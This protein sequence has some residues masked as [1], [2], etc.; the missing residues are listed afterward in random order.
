MPARRRQ[1]TRRWRR[2]EWDEVREGIQVRQPQQDPEPFVVIE[3]DQPEIQVVQCVAQPVQVLYAEVQQEVRPRVVQQVREVRSR[4]DIAKIQRLEAQLDK[5]KQVTERA[6]KMIQ[7][8]RTQVEKG[9]AFEECGEVINQIARTLWE[10][11][12]DVSEY[13]VAVP[14]YHKNG[15]ITGVPSIKDKT[16]Q[17]YLGKG[18][19]YQLHI[20][21]DVWF[22]IPGKIKVTLLMSNGG[23]VEELTRFPPQFA[24]LLHRFVFN[25]A[26]ILA[27]FL[28]KIGVECA[29]YEDI[30][31]W[32]AQDTDIPLTRDAPE[33]MGDQEFSQ[34][35]SMEELIEKEKWDTAKRKLFHWID[36]R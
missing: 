3:P 26:K 35:Q 12:M 32:F 15:Q 17:R 22:R 18:D 34:S 28:V 9:K 29:S 13:Y 5:M 2:L 1:N 16:S 14:L 21:T 25:D 30:V 19:E 20:T 7:D 10:M 31:D 6:N 8:T 27:T 23:L 4:E 24:E 33:E 36:E 11:P